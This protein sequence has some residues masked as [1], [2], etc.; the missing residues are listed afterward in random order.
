MFEWLLHVS[1]HV[2]AVALSECSLAFRPYNCD[3]IHVIPSLEWVG[4]FEILS[5]AHKTLT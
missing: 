4:L 1:D 5:L 3:Q 2:I